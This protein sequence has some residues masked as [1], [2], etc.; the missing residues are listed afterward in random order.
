MN[1][2][3]LLTMV[4]IVA[5]ISIACVAQTR[6]N[7]VMIMADDLGLA[8]NTV[9]IFYSDNG[10]VDNRFD[11]VPLLGGESKTVYPE[12]HPLRYI[13]TSNAPLRAGKGTLIENKENPQG[14]YGHVKEFP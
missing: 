9:F 1:N 2:I 7:I 13:A 12:G 10:G 5:F 11:N 4:T 3:K 8:D 14:V 6:P